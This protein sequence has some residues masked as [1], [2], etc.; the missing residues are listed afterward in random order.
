MKSMKE[1]IIKTCIY[2]VTFFF[3]NVALD[4]IVAKIKRKGQNAQ[5]Y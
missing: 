4:T 5:A 3:V 2:A 1:Y